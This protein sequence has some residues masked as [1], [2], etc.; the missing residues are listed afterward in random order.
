MRLKEDK[1]TP[2]L[3]IE[4]LPD[5]SVPQVEGMNKRSELTKEEVDFI[6]KWAKARSL[7]ITADNVINWK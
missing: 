5:R 2:Y 7:K 4:I 3:T 1:E 6:K